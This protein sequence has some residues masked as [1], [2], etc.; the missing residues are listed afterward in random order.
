MCR[1]N[2]DRLSSSFRYKKAVRIAKFPKVRVLTLLALTVP[3]MTC[4]SQRGSKCA[5]PPSLATL[6][7]MLA[8]RKT[9][10]KPPWKLNCQVSLKRGASGSQATRPTWKQYPTLTITS[11]KRLARS[12]KCHSI[13]EIKAGST[14]LA[15]ILSRWGSTMPV[16]SLLP[17][18]RQV[19][20]TGPILCRRKSR[21]GMSESLN[22]YICPQKKT[23][24]LTKPK[25]LIY[26]YS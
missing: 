21:L 7:K 9:R 1:I 4:S 26:S 5:V 20:A 8:L 11:Y 14:Y 19:I 23:S 22:R 24:R 18:L 17:N 10:H 6:H 25:E 16:K 2:Q 15:S 3:C 13:R 12:S